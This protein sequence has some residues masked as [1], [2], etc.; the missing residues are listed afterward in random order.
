MTLRTRRSA[1][2]LS[3]SQTTP[4]NASKFA[5]YRARKRAQGQRLLRVR[6]FDPTSPGLR[7]GRPTGRPAPVK[8]E[9]LDV[10]EAIWAQD[11]W[12]EGTEVTSS[13]SSPGEYGNLTGRPVGRLDRG[14]MMVLSQM[15]AG[16]LGL[17]EDQAEPVS[18]GR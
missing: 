5:R 8:T 3:M 12:P 14:T 7:G 11:G 1:L 2:L 4:E 16:Y 15:L 6:V 17:A 10:M 13:P 9:T 18:A